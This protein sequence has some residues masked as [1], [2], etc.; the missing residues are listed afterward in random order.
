MI[1]LPD[2]FDDASGYSSPIMIQIRGIDKDDLEFMY[3][4]GKTLLNDQMERYQ[5]TVH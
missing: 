2:A 4:A 3:F 1:G 5:S